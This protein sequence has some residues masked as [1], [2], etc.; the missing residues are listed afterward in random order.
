[1]SVY[2]E[3]MDSETRKYLKAEWPT[4]PRLIW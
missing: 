3:S 1:V 4:Q 2:P